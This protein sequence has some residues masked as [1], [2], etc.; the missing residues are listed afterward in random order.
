M[1]PVP[2]AVSP[3]GTPTPGDVDADGRDGRL[4]RRD[5][6]R[7]AVLDT[8]IE[9][10]SEGDLEP[11]PESIAR[12]VGISPRSVY[13]YFEDRD[14]L[15][16]A[17][18]NRHLELV[19]HLYLI[20]AIGQGDL[21]GRVRRFVECRVRLYEA[22][23]ST[24][25]AA[26]VRAV[27]DAIMRDQLELTRRALRDQIEKHFEPELSRLDTRTRRAR[28]AALDALCELEALDHYRGHRGFS[29]GETESLLADAVPALLSH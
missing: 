14:E 23:G 10:F 19:W 1:T 8:M 27:T 12:R 24:A 18:I 17:A 3:A 16:H 22:I 11:T 13:R 6:N 9:M 7:L 21:D 26:R 28:V 5:R 2:P 20:P 15:L 29:A 4:A 25:R